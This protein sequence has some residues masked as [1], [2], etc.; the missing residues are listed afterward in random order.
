M[1]NPLRN[2]APG[3]WRR[4]GYITLT[5]IG[6]CI[7]GAYAGFAAI[8]DAPPKALVFV[9]AFYGA[10]TGPLWAVPASNVTRS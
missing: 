9:A 5:S 7:T 4:V 1:S 6:L 10:V 3:R 2:I 8:G